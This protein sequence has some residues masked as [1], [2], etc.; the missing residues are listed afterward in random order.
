MTRLT[1]ALALLAGGL[2][3]AQP[4]T[5]FA[6][7]AQRTASTVGPVGMGVS[8]WLPDQG[9]SP[10]DSLLFGFGSGSLDP[11]PLSPLGSGSLTNVPAQV[12]AIATA[13]GVIVNGTSKTLIAVLGNGLVSFYTIKSVSPG[14]DQFVSAG[15]LTIDAGTQIALSAVPGGRAALLVADGFR[16]RRFDLDV[17]GGTV[18]AIQGGNISASPPA[19]TDQSNALVFDG[20]SNV[21]FVGGRVLGDIYRF[22]AR[23]DAGDPSSFDIALLSQGRLAPPVTGLA[24]YSGTTASYLLAANGQGLTIYDLGSATPLT[25]A[26]RVI[27][28]DAVSQVTAPAGV[29]V[30]NLPVV[31]GGFDGGLIAVGD[32]TQTDLALLQWDMLAGQVDGGLTVD[33]SFDPRVVSLPDAG[34]DGGLPDAGAPDGGGG[35]G[36]G[37]I[38]G[39]GG[40]GIP[41]DHGSSCASAAGAPVL[42]LLLAGLGLLPRRRQRR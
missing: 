23:M 29:A 18:A 36:N 16:I 9:T 1:F 24:L 17:S 27:P 40:P 42:L 2:V 32:R 3:V 34:V 39:G 6:P 38:P 26:F 31:A 22:D 7:I 25:S 30:M 15:P 4:S 21:G 10:D 35:G 33:P 28:S 37:G 13:P 20:M 5:Y 12:D 8:L 41:V 14:V 11:F 19:A